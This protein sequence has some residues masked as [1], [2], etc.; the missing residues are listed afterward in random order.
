MFF[1]MLIGIMSSTFD[2]VSIEKDKNALIEHTR[3]YY[4]YIKGIRFTKKMLNKRYLYVIQPHVEEEDTQFK[5]SI[6]D[7]KT[8]LKKSHTKV[9]ESIGKTDPSLCLEISICIY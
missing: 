2:R 7:L 8:Y 1:N 9:I 6:R 3:I 5:E 4:D